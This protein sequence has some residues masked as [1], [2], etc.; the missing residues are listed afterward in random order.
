MCTGLSRQAGE[1]GPLEVESAAERLPG[2]RGQRDRVRM[3]KACHTTV[4]FDL[5]LRDLKEA[6]SWDEAEFLAGLVFLCVEAMSQRQRISFAA[7]QDLKAKVWTA[8]ANAR[9]RAAEW[10]KA[11]LALSN[12]ERFRTEGTGGPHPK[13]VGNREESGKPRP[14]REPGLYTMPAFYGVE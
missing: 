7:D 12:A 9:R 14:R 2:R 6:P 1:G 4:F 5:V 8:V 10:E 3:S 11:H 13:G